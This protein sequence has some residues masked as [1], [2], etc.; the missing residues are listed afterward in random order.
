MLCDIDLA[1]EAG[2]SLAIT[3]DSGSGKSTLLQLLAGILVPLRGE[4]VFDEKP[5][6]SLPRRQR[7]HI[8]L[9]HFGF[10]FQFG[11]LLHELTL[12][13]NVEL[14]LLFMGI[15]RSRAR[16]LARAALDGVGLEEL[17]TRYPHQVSGGQQQRAAIARAVAHRPRVLLADE[18][19]GSLDEET[20]RVVMDLLLETAGAQDTTVIVVTHSRNVAD[21]CK[22]VLRVGGGALAEVVS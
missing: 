11:E 18:P 20:S 1:I 17:G 5:F 6:S 15:K 13:E 8:R 14:P 4:V 12:A 19:T 10:V 7:D 22:R 9:Q 2:S 16:E 21:R 3:G